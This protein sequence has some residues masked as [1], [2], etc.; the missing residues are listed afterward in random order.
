MLKDFVTLLEKIVDLMRQRKVAREQTFNTVIDPLFVE[1]APVV[2]DYFSLFRQAR[3]LLRESESVSDDMITLIRSRREEFLFGRIEIRSQVEAIG[4]NTNDQDLIGF[5]RSIGAL[6]YS[7]EFTEPDSFGEH[8][9]EVLEQC[10]DS[11]VEYDD[12]AGW[13]HCV[14][15]NLESNW[16]EV[17]RSYAVLRLK[18]VSP[19]LVLPETNQE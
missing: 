9:V 2:A 1:V 6:F 17:V 4:A 5:S 11:H 19:H 7:S 12:A 10:A 3:D 16:A 8:L 13:M 14:I 18:Y 15:R